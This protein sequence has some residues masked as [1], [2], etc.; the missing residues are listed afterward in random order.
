[1]KTIFRHPTELPH[2]TFSYAGTS[3]SVPN[4][5]REN[6][7]CGKR[8][9][10]SFE[11]GGGD[12]GQRRPRLPGLAEKTHHRAVRHENEMNKPIATKVSTPAIATP[13]QMSARS[14][15]ELIL[16]GLSSTARAPVIHMNDA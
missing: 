5:K 15:S 6:V 9:T 1:M 4:S 13:R 8:D 12:C 14:L 3:N 10:D 11:R 2:L 16:T 7:R